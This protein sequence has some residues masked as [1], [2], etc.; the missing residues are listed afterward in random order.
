ML[1]DQAYHLIVSILELFMWDGELTGAENLEAGPAVIVA[2]HMGA[3]G[4]VGICSSLPMRLYPWVLGATVDKVE[5]PENVRKDFVEKV[6]KL[7]PPLSLRV[8][9]G[10]CK[11]STPLILGIGCIPVPVTHE[12][13]AALFETSIAL[14]KQGKFLLIVPEDPNAEPDSLTGIRPFKHGFLRLGELYHQ[15]EGKRLPFYPVV[16]H[17]A[18]LVVVGKPILY[19]PL[20]EP[21]LERMRMVNILETTIKATHLE[22][23]ESQVIQPI[24][25][26][27]KTS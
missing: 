16:I 26:K 5:G 12:A 22:I 19:N 10:L 14:L 3:I 2:N 24:F 15:V 4:P 9:K 11:I 17:E 7:K 20:N 18:G 8:A 13:Q 21:K 27:R 1:S 23:T 25:F 6:L